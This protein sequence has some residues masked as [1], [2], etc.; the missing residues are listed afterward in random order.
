MSV[1]AQKQAMATQSQVEVGHSATV[2]RINPNSLEIMNLVKKIDY[3]NAKY[4][5]EDLT[6]F[7]KIAT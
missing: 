6:R 2:T 7:N 5:S 3:S 4:R 1:R